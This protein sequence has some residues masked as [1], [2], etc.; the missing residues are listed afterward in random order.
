MKKLLLTT[1]AAVALVGS[2]YAQGTL[3]FQTGTGTILKQT[4]AADSASVQVGTGAA[5]GLF[6]LL[7]APA[8]TTDLALFS[9]V[10]GALVSCSP[11]AGRLTGGSRT[12]NGIAAGAIVSVVFRG[13]TGGAADWTSSTAAWDLG[14]IARGYSSIMSVDTGDPTT[15]PAGTPGSFPGGAGILLTYSAVP[16]PSSMALAGLGAA[17]LLMFRRRK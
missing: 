7:W 9:S 11:T 4:S 6:E 14:Q 10:P 17:S 13:W 16:E 12:I 8:G 2:S 15:T 3:L 1:L 5:N